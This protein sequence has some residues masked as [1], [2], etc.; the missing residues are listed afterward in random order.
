MQGNCSQSRREPF[1]IWDF[2]GDFGATLSQDQFQLV[3]MTNGKQREPEQQQQQRQ[4]GGGLPSSVTIVN[5]STPLVQH[6]RSN[7]SRS[8]S[9]QRHAVRVLSLSTEPSLRKKELTGIAVLTVSA[10]ALA[11]S[12][13]FVKLSEALSLNFLEIA[14]ARA[15]LQT[16]F[17]LVGCIFLT[18]NPLGPD[19]RVRI[20][21][22]TRG[23][24]GAIGILLFYYSLSKLA[25]A[26]ATGNTILSRVTVI[27]LILYPCGS[28]VFPR[29]CFYIRSA[30]H[31]HQ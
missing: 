29:S 19:A 20:W 6:G 24:V 26:E 7:N 14:F 13:L 12:S 30:W 8:G 25:L 18:I 17:A 22:L 1:F 3:K 9:Q 31:I 21:L 23:F 27:L 15:S 4:Q 11:A 5:E 16:A 28:L 10:T 2:A